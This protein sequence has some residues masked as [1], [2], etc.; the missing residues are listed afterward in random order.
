MLLTMSLKWKETIVE[1][2]GEKLLVEHL[3]HHDPNKLLDALEAKPVK[4]LLHASAPITVHKFG[5]HLLAVRHFLHGNMGYPQ[6]VVQHPA[7]VAFASLKQF[8]DEKAAF[9]EMPIAL[10]RVRYKQD[11][12]SRSGV[13][14]ATIWKK[15]MRP[16][17]NYLE[18]RKVSLKAKH[19]AA[20]STMRE[21]AKLHSRGLQFGQNDLRDFVVNE[22]G[23]VK[24]TGF[25]SLCKTF[26]EVL[27]TEAE[28]IANKLA[29]H[30]RGSKSKETR[31]SLAHLLY[32]HYYESRAKLL[33]AE[34]QKDR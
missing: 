3:A 27:H 13:W 6:Y 19:A 28:I 24:L 31:A 22:K 32:L 1:R 25:T 11:P 15:G 29:P 4:R 10:I 23:A 34:M 30:I 2:G 33:D 8:A 17:V 16:L 14:L 26:D 20:V 18:S 7:F 9:S 5:P 12:H 21:L